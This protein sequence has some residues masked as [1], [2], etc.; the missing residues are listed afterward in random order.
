[1]RQLTLNEKISIKGQLAVKGVVPCVLVKLGTAEA[2]ELY[3]ACYGRPVSTFGTR[4]QWR[5]NMWRERQWRNSLWRK[6]APH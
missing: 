5:K 6:Q 2:I 4:S 3:W 1:M